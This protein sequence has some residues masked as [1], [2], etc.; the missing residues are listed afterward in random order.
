MCM[1]NRSSRALIAIAAFASFAGAFVSAPLVVRGEGAIVPTGVASPAPRT[2]SS[3]F[4][5][6]VPRRDPFDGAPPPARRT[7][8][9]GEP[10]QLPARSAPRDDSA[11]VMPP[12][13]PNAGAG[14]APFPFAVAATPSPGTAAAA[15]YVVAVATGRT[16]YALIQEAGTLRLVTLSDRL[17][18][19]TVVAIR[20][21]G[22]HLANG[23]ALPFASASAVTQAPLRTPEPLRAPPPPPPSVTQR[24][25]PES[26]P[27]AP[28]LGTAAGRPPR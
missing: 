24:S 18:P 25:V 17:G 19:D 21:D 14:A 26:L 3:A 2:A 1:L 15:A 22:V 4:G 23:R 27:A 6:V 28:P 20:A 12:L 9:S 8:A 7:V 11:G 16:P 5:D 13:P 10:Q